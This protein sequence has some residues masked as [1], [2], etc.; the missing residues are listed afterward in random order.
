MP[1]FLS[2]CTEEKA[3]P[4]AQ[5]I[6]Q[7]TVM[8]VNDVYRIAGIEQGQIGSMARIRSLRRQLQEKDPGLILINAGD[9]L[10]PSSLSLVFKG[11]QMVDSMNMLNGKGPAFDDR[12]F[13]TFGN[14]ELDPPMSSALLQERI[15]NSRFTW[16]GGNM[17]WKKDQNDQDII[18]APNLLPYKIIEANGIKVGLFSLTIDSQQ[19]QYVHIDNNYAERAK[20]LTRELRNLGAEVVIAVTHLFDYQDRRILEKLGARG[21]DVIFGG[22]DHFRLNL[23]VGGRMVIK[24]DAEAET[25][26]VATI[27]ID[28]SDKVVTNFYY[29]KL[30]SHIPQDSDTLALVANWLEKFKTHNCQK[31]NPG[32]TCLDENRPATDVILAGKQQDIRLYESNL[33]NWLA[34]IAKDSFAEDGAEIALLNSGSIRLNQNLPIGS[35]LNDFTIGEMLPFGSSLK[36]LRLNGYQLQAVLNHSV[37][38]WKG[39]GKWLQISG[40]AFIHDPKT[41]TARNLHLL[42]K[43]GPKPI[44]PEQK[45]KVVIGDYMV[46]PQ[47]DQDGYVMLNPGQ[48]MTSPRQGILLEDQVKAHLK[49][50]NGQNIAPGLEGRICNAER[51]GPCQVPAP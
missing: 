24:A 1:F 10:L 14:H 19:P 44:M 2:A 18:Q 12:F 31:R 48:E 37:S 39:H 33:G 5:T 40:L 45:Y 21:P 11:E 26:T 22:H 43:D 51:P 30:D 20:K 41:E 4:A 38:D 3:A 28:P 27:S 23:N 25:A 36:L 47:N 13:V 42:T 8:S 6:R 35:I 9:F 34:D 49:S 7:F 50:L 16:L 15:E 17:E 46:D 32:G 29:Q